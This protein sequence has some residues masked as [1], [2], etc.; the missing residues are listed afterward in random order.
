MRKKNRIIDIFPMLLFL[1]FTLSALGIVTFS[2]QIYRNIVERAEGRFDTETAAAYISEKV[3]N[4]DQNGSVSLSEFMGNKAVEIDETIKEVSYVTYIYVYDGYLREL[5]TEKENLSKCTAADGNE[6]LPMEAMNLA[7]MSERLL[8][9]DFTDTAG[10]TEESFIAIK[11][12]KYSE[13][14]TATAES[15]EPEGDEP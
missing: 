7:Y 6:I 5:F 2:V 9:L 15:G 3:R 14:D 1:I 13:T 11:S 4:H 12:K 8:K 10:K